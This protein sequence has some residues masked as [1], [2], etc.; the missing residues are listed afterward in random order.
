MC[1]T[2]WVRGLKMMY[3]KSHNRLKIT[4]KEILAK[5]PNFRIKLIMHS[6]NTGLITTYFPNP[7]QSL[8]TF[9]TH[10]CPEL[11]PSKK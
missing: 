1:G 3:L 9:L 7:I 6:I 10:N 11:R 2:K 5:H 8:F 4:F